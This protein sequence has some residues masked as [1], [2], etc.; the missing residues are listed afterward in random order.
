[1][2]VLDSSDFE[3]AKIT[4]ALIIINVA[5]FVF[6]ESPLG[7]AYAIYFVQYNIK[8]LQELQLWRLFTSMFLH[9]DVMHLFS[10]LL[11]LLLFG[12]LVERD[13]SKPQYMAIYF[14]SGLLGSIFSLL[15]FPPY[16]ISL[17]AS[18]AVFGLLG[19]SFIIIAT[20]NPSLLILALAYI[21]FFLI[22]SLSPGI[23]IW[24][25][26]FG[27]IGGVALGYTFKKRGSRPERYY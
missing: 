4:S 13:Y 20:E 16:T 11:A 10:N 26:L 21:A 14:V 2:Y 3:R 12:A 19:A 9:G 6:F 27:L 1:M 23:N 5:C 22:S 7:E 15:L 18:G 24:A 25:H 17:G 8:I